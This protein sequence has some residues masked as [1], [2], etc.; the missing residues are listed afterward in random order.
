MV[1]RELSPFLHEIA[2]LELRYRFM[3]FLKD[4]GIKSATPASDEAW[5]AYMMTISEL[6]VGG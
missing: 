6:T 3:F 2:I 5:Q 1:K 4:L